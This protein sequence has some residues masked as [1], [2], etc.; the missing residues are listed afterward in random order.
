MAP[1]GKRTSLPAI[2]RLGRVGGGKA[3]RLC[4]GPV[5]STR[6]E[7]DRGE[8]GAKLN[9]LPAS[10][11]WHSRQICVLARQMQLNLGQSGYADARPEGVMAGRPW[12]DRAGGWQGNHPQR[13]RR[14]ALRI[15]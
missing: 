1:T 15:I 14:F 12:L 6:A 2:G 9:P 8:G 7:D 5:I 13:S 4:D 10:C 3:N 11:Y